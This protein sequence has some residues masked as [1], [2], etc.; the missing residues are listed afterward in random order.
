MPN[1]RVTT[2][3][4]AVVLSAMMACDT[5]TVPTPIRIEPDSP[6]ADVQT[7]VFTEVQ[8]IGMFVFNDSALSLRRNQACVSC[9]DKKWGFSSPNVLNSAGGAVMPGS[10][11]AFGSRKTPSAAYASPAPVR[12]LDP[13]EG[14][15]GGM[16]W[17]GRATGSRL[18]SPVADQSLLPFLS[19]AEMALTDLAC[20]LYGIK[21]SHYAARFIKHFGTGLSLIKF[22]TNTNQLCPLAAP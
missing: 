20:V 18:G 10:T 2:C 7:T 15:V 21:Q 8:E 22:P 12:F 14:F 6:L 4:L 16:F 17:D 9:H 3:C 5:P 11:G 13:V 19:P 1:R